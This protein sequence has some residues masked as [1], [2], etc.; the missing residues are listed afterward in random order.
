MESKRR[1]EIRKREKKMNVDFVLVCGRL[2]I[3]FQTHRNNVTYHC[4]IHFTL[5]V[6]QQCVVARDSHLFVYL[7][8][9]HHVPHELDCLVQVPI[10]CCRLSN[11]GNKSDFT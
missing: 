1:H 6:V 9:R 7:L 10:H 3:Q 2:L 11:T 5:A 8:H 4:G